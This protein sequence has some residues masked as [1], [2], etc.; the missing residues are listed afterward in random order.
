MNQIEISNKIKILSNKILQQKKNELFVI[1]ND[2]L[3]YKRLH[4]YELEKYEKI[5]KNIFIF[6]FIYIFS[7]SKHLIKNFIKILISISFYFKKQNIDKKKINTMFVTYKFNNKY[8]LKN[9]SYFKEIYAKLNKES[10]KF[11]IVAVN[12][13]KDFLNLKKKIYNYYELNKKSDLKLEFNIFFLTLFF[14]IKYLIIGISKFDN[15]EKKFYLLLSLSFLHGN[16][17]DNI[18]YYHQIKFL[19]KKKKPKSIV[20][21]YEGHALERVIFRAAKKI[22]PKIRT[23]AYNHTIIS[24]NYNAIFLK[25]GKIN[26]PDNLIFANQIS[27]KIYITKQKIKKQ[28]LFCVSKNKEWKHKVIRDRKYCLVAPEG[29]DS[30]NIKL[31][32]FISDYLKEFNNLKFLWRFHPIYFGKENSFIKKN[33]KNFSNFKNKIILSN[34]SIDYDFKISKFLLYRGSTTVVKGLSKNLIPINLKIKDGLQNNYFLDSKNFS[35]LVVTKPKDLNKLILDN[36][37]QNK[38][39]SNK[40]R[41]LNDY[42]IINNNIKTK[43]FI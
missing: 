12:H 14:C 8:S 43:Y 33:F 36:K 5:K 35:N 7:F 10:K 6:I 40:K 42:A 22:N 9:D 17:T 30:E 1:C 2:W 21:I 32:N 4:P 15:F 41:I 38:I 26:D 34:N 27:K 20:S 31:F 11:F 16:T 39:L 25:L 28:K 19:I 37:M 24:S 13:Q 3:Y 29:L 18:K 23:I